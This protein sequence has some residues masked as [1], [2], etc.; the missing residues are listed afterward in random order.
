MSNK[1]DHLIPTRRSELVIVN[2]KRELSELAV[3]ADY[4]VKINENENRDKY[5]D[6]ARELK[7][8][9][10]MKVTLLPI[11]VKAL[12]SKRGRIV[13]NRGTS[14]DHSNNR[15]V[16]IAQNTEMSPGNVRRL[17]DTQ[18]PVKNSLGI[19]MILRYKR[20]I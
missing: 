5:L 16:K 9:W 10:N 18:T 2:K 19:I 11:V 3:Q 17:A 1:K 13:G 7:K 20:I 6:L 14:R 8:L 4:T 15:I 12:R